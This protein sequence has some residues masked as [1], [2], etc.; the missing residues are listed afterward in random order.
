MMALSRLLGA[1]LRTIRDMAAR[2]AEWWLE[3]M[4]GMLPR[5][6]RA[7][8]SSRARLVVRRDGDA[9][10]YCR[11]I[12]GQWSPVEPGPAARPV[13]CLPASAGLSRAVRLPLMPASDLRRM[14]GLDIDRLTPFEADQVLIDFDIL[15]R[16]A[17]GQT[18][19]VG[20][21]RREDADAALD[22]ARTRG[23]APAGLA[24]E[25]DAGNPR[26]DFLSAMPK[27]ARPGAHWTPARL[28][29]LAAV[30]AGIN[31]AG[32]TLSDIA[33]VET[34]RQQAE[35]RH[36]LALSAAKLRDSIGAEAARRTVLLERK[37]LADP[38]P[39]LDSLTVSLPD[40]VWIQRLEW[41]GTAVR[42]DGWSLDLD[43]TGLLALI[44]ADPLLANARIETPP[45][46]PRPPRRPFEIVANREPGGAR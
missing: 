26:F 42:L 8:G 16:D 33:A 40:T 30:L 14:I 38:L 46:P 13:L 19:A 27:T 18:V 25:D 45:F 12:D 34:L 1:D 32:L 22:H 31:L 23:L 6:W 37:R 28:W 39:L 20:I 11:Y 2:G 29:G 9:Y 41:D 15:S 4:R 43:D 7:D 3:E 35:A 44:E 21:V 5:R 17:S 36:P 24:L 10:R